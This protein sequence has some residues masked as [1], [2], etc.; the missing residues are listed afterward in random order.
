M[1]PIILTFFVFFFDS[2]FLN[3]LLRNDV[4]S[5]IIR[6][7]SPKGL[8]RNQTMSL[9]FRQDHSSKKRYSFVVSRTLVFTLLGIRN[10]K[11]TKSLV[12]LQEADIN[13]SARIHSMFS[14]SHGERFRFGAMPEQTVV[15]ELAQ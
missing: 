5:P 9:I 3:L 12:S 11:C 13:S 15:F 4:A 7:K 8:H 2:H 14:K 6:A 10:A 1:I